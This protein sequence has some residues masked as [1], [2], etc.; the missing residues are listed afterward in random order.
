MWKRYRC[1]TSFFP[2]VDTC[3]SCEDTA[4]QSCAMVPKWG[5]LRSVFS[6]SRLQHISDMH[7]KF[8][9]RLHQSPTAEI[10]REKKTS[11]LVFTAQLRHQIRMRPVRNARWT[12]CS[13][14][15]S[16]RAQIPNFRTHSVPN[17][18]THPMSSFWTY[19]FAAR[20]FHTLPVGNVVI[21]CAAIGACSKH[22]LLA[23][24]A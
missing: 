18:W 13:V 23:V 1:L 17:L 3:L 7:S 9:L 24:G 8:A 10:R 22:A 6:A 19:L 14:A 20:L 12:S 15:S 4:R 2:V 5:F 16:E 11:Q 21:R